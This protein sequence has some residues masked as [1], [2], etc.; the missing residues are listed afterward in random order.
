MKLKNDTTLDIAFCKSRKDKVFKNKKVT[1][2]SF[3]L[4]LSK[5]KRTSET[6]SQYIA[7]NK[8]KQDD[9][10]DVGGFVGGYLEEGSRKKVK[11][12]QL[13]CLD[14]DFGDPGIWDNW[15]LLYGN[16]SCVYT[17]HK[18]TSENYRFRLIIPLD[19]KVNSD[20]YQAVARRIANDLGI[21]HFDDTTYQ[22]NRLMYFPSTSSDGK[23]VFQYEDAPFLSVDEV[24]NTYEDWRDVSS[25]PTS[26]RVIKD[27][28]HE[29]KKQTDPT[30]KKGVVGAF[31]KAY[32]IQ[33]AI[34][35][36]LSDVYRECDIPNRYTFVGGSTSGGVVVYD[37]KFAYSHHATDPSSMQLCNAFDLVRIHKFGYL[38]TEVVEGCP[39]NRYPSYVKTLEFL[40]K[41]ERVKIELG[42]EQMSDFENV[43]NESLDWLSKLSYTKQ[44]VI[45]ATTDNVVLVLEND[46]KLKNCLGYNEFEHREVALKDLPWRKVSSNPYWSDA[47]DAEL[48]YYLEKHYNI[49]GKG[50]VDDAVIS[51]IHKNTFHPVR[52]YLDSC[53]W[54]GV[55]RVDTLFIDYLGA[56]DSEY[57]RAVTRKVLCGAVAR[58]YHPGIKF[59]NV[60]V[61]IGKQGLGK[62][63]LV[64]LLGGP[65]YSDSLT[66]VTGKEAYEQLQGVWLMEMG[67]LAAMKKAE[68][69]ATKLFVSKQED[70]YRVAYGRRVENFPRQ[71]IFI[72][73]TNEENFL[74]DSTGNRRFW[75]VDCSYGAEKSMWE[76]LT[77]EVVKRVWGEAKTLYEKGEPLHL[78]RDLEA[79]AVEKQE[80]H[81]EENA[82]QG[83]VESYL[84]I[85]LPADWEGKSM[86]ERRAYVQDEELIKEQGRIRRNKVCILEVWVELFNGDPKKLST[87]DSRE[88]NKI[89]GNLKGWKR[90]QHPVRFGDLY[91]RQRGYRREGSIE[92][93]ATKL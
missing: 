9:I 75:P 32:S 76:E 51:V 70:R 20:E 68:V 3:L 7:F 88:I 73:T 30:E 61:L 34:S 85:K 54:D 84:E 5:T 42:K 18:H 2:G 60:A 48:R 50:K 69:E 23:Y 90:S 53:E 92:D 28:K 39:I 56:E 65:W 27:I 45:Q 63:Q 24:L 47:D 58:V 82:K 59:D 52:D 77:P 80:S 36:Y 14:C 37:D 13:I 11:F 12:R 55:N 1:W 64:K 26:S 46:S 16:A 40:E 41:D 78:N 62:S 29:I 6:V 33:E 87:Y 44:G 22:A 81:Q 93:V 19:R 35:T 86:A 79:C 71:T 15:L 21:D 49:V 57:I 67:E 25:W 72:G 91:G 43:D 4:T 89:L 10:K 31:C 38:D 74:R 8:S 66:T 83:M 17:T